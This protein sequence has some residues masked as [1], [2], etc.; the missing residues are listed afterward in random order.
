MSP[1]V[2]LTI[3]LVLCLLS[4]VVLGTDRSMQVCWSPQFSDIEPL[5]SEDWN[6]VVA[7]GYERRHVHMTFC[8][9]RHGGK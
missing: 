2:A 9:L 7:Q 5:K 3:F 6:V 8:A 4:V 1:Q